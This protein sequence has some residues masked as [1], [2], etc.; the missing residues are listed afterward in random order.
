MKK[1]MQIIAL[2]GLVGLG[3][4]VIAEDGNSEFGELGRAIRL[5]PKL[6][7][8]FGF[9]FRIDDLDNYSYVPSVT[10]RFY[11]FFHP[12]VALRAGLT[13]NSLTRLNYGASYHTLATDVGLRFNARETRLIPFLETGFTFP[14]YWGIDRGF[15][16]T[17]FQPGVRFAVG[18]SIGVTSDMAF[19]FAVSQILNQMPRSEIYPMSPVGP[20]AACPLGLYCRPQGNPRGA[21]NSTQVEF[22]VRMGL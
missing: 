17:D 5:E 21:Y 11:Y 6:Q 7:A 10:G 15:E 4:P 16:Y 12:V 18:L 19:D 2:L 8:G 22:A 20:D 1:S 3:A 9:D 13:F 14:L